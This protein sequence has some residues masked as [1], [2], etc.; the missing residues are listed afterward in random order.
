MIRARAAREQKTALIQGKAAP[1]KAWELHFRRK[2][3]FEYL[4]WR[5]KKCLSLNADL[6]AAHTFLSE[7]GENMRATWV[8]MQIELYAFARCRRS[9]TPPRRLGRSRLWS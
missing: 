5:G 1:A 9:T 7:R 2:A 6:L 4:T 3:A 8:V